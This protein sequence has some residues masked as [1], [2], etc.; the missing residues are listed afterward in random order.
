MAAVILTHVHQKRIILTVNAVADVLVVAAATTL[1]TSQRS[2]AEIRS[3]TVIPTIEH[4]TV[5]IN[6]KICLRIVLMIRGLSRALSSE[7]V[8]N[9]AISF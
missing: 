5:K 4:R 8:E 3:I 7:M 2:R 6:N 9:S 1:V